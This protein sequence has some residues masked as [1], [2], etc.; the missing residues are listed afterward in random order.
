MIIYFL[1][2]GNDDERFIKKII[3]PYIKRKY[4]VKIIKYSRM[5][6][7][8]IFNFIKSIKSTGDY[9]FLADLD[10]KKCVTEKKEGIKNRFKNIGFAKQCKIVVVFPYFPHYMKP[11]K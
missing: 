7:E 4:E 3:T 11:Q 6:K 2:E 8:K 5:R 10:R 1:V 9:F